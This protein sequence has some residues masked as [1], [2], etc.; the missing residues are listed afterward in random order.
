MVFGRARTAT[1]ATLG[2]LGK[3]A[4]SNVME[5]CASHATSEG[6]AH[7]KTERVLALPIRRMGFGIPQM[8]AQVASQDTME[9]YAKINAR[10]PADLAGVRMAGQAMAPACVTLD[11]VEIPHSRPIPLVRHVWQR[12][13]DLRVVGPARRAA[14]TEPAPTVCKE[15]GSVDA[16]MGGRV[17]S[18]PSVAIAPVMVASAAT[19][20]V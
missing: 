13:S 5:G 6:L 12:T 18:A 1:S 3:T 8:A 14:R 4:I 2:M 20:R 16:K 19:E 9:R 15:Q 7:A 11:S 10:T 17:A